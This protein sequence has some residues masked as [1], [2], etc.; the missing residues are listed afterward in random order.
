M[1]SPLRN[2]RSHTGTVREQS[3]IAAY[4]RFM[5]VPPQ[6]PQRTAPA[7]VSPSFLR[8]HPILAGFGLL[9][10]LSLF[11]AWWPV[12]A[13]ITGVVVA[14]RATGAD[15]AAW[16]W[17]RGTSSRVAGRLR[18]TWRD[19]EARRQ[20]HE[21]VEHAPTPAAPPEP[22]PSEPAPTPARPVPAPPAPAPP[23]PLPQP[24]R[25]HAAHLRA[26]LRRERTPRRP[27]QGAPAVAGIDERDLGV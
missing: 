13:V 22:A 21:P 6:P 10:G 5:P 16:R 2:A 15:V 19:L 4:A 3:P 1:T 12:S 20:G 24:G 17:L 26:P 18:R 23:P 25:G 14:G 11:A 7:P 9:A 8:R 27:A